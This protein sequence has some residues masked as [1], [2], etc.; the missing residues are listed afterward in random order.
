[1]L[2]GKGTNAWLLWE[3]TATEC[4]VARTVL[5]FPGEGGVN[6]NDVLNVG[7]TWTRV[8]VSASMTRQS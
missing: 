8:W 3:S 1:M 5:F 4:A 7:T 2:A 6:V